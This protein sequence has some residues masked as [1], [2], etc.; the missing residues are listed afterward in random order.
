MTGWTAVS[1]VSEDT[2]VVDRISDKVRTLAALKPALVRLLEWQIDQE[3][4][5]TEKGGRH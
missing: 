4:E 5:R 3:L 2:P 1:T